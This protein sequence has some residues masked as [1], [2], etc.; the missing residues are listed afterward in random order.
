MIINDKYLFTVSPDNDDVKLYY[1]G[2]VDSRILSLV[3]DYINT[4]QA[5]NR[6]SSRKLF[7]IFL[8]LAQNISDYSDEIIEIGEKKIGGGIIKITETESNIYL[9]TGNTV[10]KENVSDLVDKCAYIN[11]LDRESLR[12]YKRYERSKASKPSGNAG[13]GLIQV[14][15]TSENPLD[16]EIYSIN[17]TKVHFS[18]IVTIDK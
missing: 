10:K 9:S 16:V 3:G 1:K 7:K 5:K 17:E 12:K 2:P 6:N 15:L 4:L 14:A 18:I 13:I 11:S 8:E